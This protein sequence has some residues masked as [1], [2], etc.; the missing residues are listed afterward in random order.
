MEGL[1]PYS[2]RMVVCIPVFLSP[3]VH[4]SFYIASDF[5]VF[6][7]FAFVVF[8]LAFAQAQQHLCPAFFEI[9]FQG[10]QGQA[11]LKGQGGEVLDL[12]A[13]HEHFA[14]ALGV[15]I[16]LVGLGVFGN[17]SLEEAYARVKDNEVWLMGCDISEYT[18]A[19]HFNHHP[20]RRRKLLIHRHEIKRFAALA[21]QK[22][23]TLVPLKMYFK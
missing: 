13:V 1:I 15:V 4:L 6:H 16:E 3:P 14:R 8:L 2:T 5:G 7:G 18:E 10:H 22:G 23:L 20:K 9:H 17:V 21:F 19:N 12:A 11:F